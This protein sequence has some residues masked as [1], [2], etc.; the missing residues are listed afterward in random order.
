M[1]LRCL[2]K[3]CYYHKILLDLNIF[4]MGVGVNRYC[5]V[6]SYQ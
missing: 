5:I 4:S 3:K 2:R 6:R 1:I